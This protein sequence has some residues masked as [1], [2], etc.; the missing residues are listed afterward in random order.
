MTRTIQQAGSDAVIVAAA[1][2]PIGTAFKGALR[3]V[4]AMELAAIVVKE[5]QERSGLEPSQ[6]D[7]IILA[8]SNYGGGDIARHA[9][10]VTGMLQVPGQALNRHCAGGLTAIGN[11]A[12]Q[13]VAG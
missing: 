10:V 13:I 1:R 7:D 9:A 12:A 2:T 5:V 8:E 4:T 11:A 3:D 6:I